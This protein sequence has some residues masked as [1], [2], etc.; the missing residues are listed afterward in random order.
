MIIRYFWRLRVYGR[1]TPYGVLLVRLNYRRLQRFNDLLSPF[2]YLSI[3]IT[4]LVC[5]CPFKM[6]TVW[7]LPKVRSAGKLR[8]TL[9]SHCIY[10]QRLLYRL[11]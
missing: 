8:Y 9:V 10:H 3:L 2:H 5:F 11:P 4:N 7:S 6:A 1:D